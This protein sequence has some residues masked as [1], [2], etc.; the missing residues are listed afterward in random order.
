MRRRRAVLRGPRRIPPSQRRLGGWPR[1]VA[2]AVCLAL[3]PVAMRAAGIAV[4]AMILGVCVVLIAYEAARYADA[5]ARIRAE[6]IG[7]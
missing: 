6:R 1:I 7:H 5:R 3:I 4:L 2:A